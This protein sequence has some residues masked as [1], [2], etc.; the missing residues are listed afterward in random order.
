MVIDHVVLVLVVLSA[1]L[2]RHSLAG[3]AKYEGIAL[4]VAAKAVV[5]FALGGWIGRERRSRR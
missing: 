5:L 2:F 1:V 3:D 4:I